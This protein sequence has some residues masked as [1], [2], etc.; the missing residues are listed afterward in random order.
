MSR[1]E[2]VE[3]LLRAFTRR[4]LAAIGALADAGLDVDAL[5]AGLTVLMRAVLRGDAETVEWVLAAGADPDARSSDGK[6][7][8]DF[9]RDLG[10]SDL[11]ELLALAGSQAGEPRGES[12]VE[13]RLIEEPPLP[14]PAGP[15]ARGA[16]LADDLDES[17]DDEIDDDVDLAASVWL[18]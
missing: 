8:L 6:R 14:L 3:D 4:D 13:V 2:E 16:D 7:A 18:P 10:R 11:A 12:E 5:G 17:F 9:A 1:Q 15:S